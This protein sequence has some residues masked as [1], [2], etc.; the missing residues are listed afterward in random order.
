LKIPKKIVQPRNVKA[1]ESDRQ[2]LDS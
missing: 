2:K 1:Q